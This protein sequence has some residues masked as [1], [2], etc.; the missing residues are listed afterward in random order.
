MQTNASQLLAEWLEAPLDELAPKTCQRYR[1]A[2]QGFLGWFAQVERR[3]LTLT[4]LHPI[5]LVGYRSWLQQK[6]SSSTVNTHLC[7]LRTWCAWL[8][9]KGYLETNPSARLKLVRRQEPLAPSALTP[10]Q[11][12]ALLRQ[13]QHTRYPARN[14]A[15]MQILLQTGLRI[16]ECASLTWQDITFG[17]RKGSVLVR[18]GKGNKSRQVPLN[19]SARQALAD[20]VASLLKVASTLHDVAMAWSTGAPGTAPLWTSERGSPLSVR[21]MSRMIAELVRDC[22]VRDAVPAE[23]TPHSL[24]HTFATRY[25]MRHPGDIVGLARLLGHTSI[26]TTQVYV[27]PTDADMAERVNQMDINAYAS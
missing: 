14:L 12:N 26:Q 20:Y 21:E 1:S 24:R 6:A 3:P 19:D 8:A 5:A 10:A 13:A 9:E 23:T 16:G 27:Q 25:L 22:A 17:E 15:V 7:A 4:D 18:A 2:V 11:V